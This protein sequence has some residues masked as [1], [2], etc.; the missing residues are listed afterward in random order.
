MLQA[1]RKNAY[2]WTIRVLLVVLIGVFCFWGI[3]TGFFS[4]VHPIA[5]VNGH[6][7]LGKQ[8][9]AQ[10][11]RLENTFH[12]VYGDNT[13]AVL[14][15]VNIRELALEQL[16]EQHLLESQAKRLGITVSDNE[17]AQAIKSQAAFQI[18]GQFSVR[19]YNAVLRDNQLDP[20]TFEQ[21]T[22][23]AMLVDSMRQMI[24]N[25]VQISPAQ[26]RAA[27]NRVDQHLSM[28]YVVFPYSNFV[29][30][31]HPTDKELQTFYKADKQAFREPE[32]VKI[33]YIR[34]DPLVLAS[35]FTPSEAQIQDYYQQHRDSEFTQSEEVRARHILIAV[36]PDA[37]P[38][39]H[40]A[41]KAKAEDI[42]KQLK[43]GADFA[44]LAKQYSDDPGTRDHGGELG[45]FT[46][47]EMVKPFAE[48]AFS[49]KPGQYTVAQSRFGYHIIQVQQV[50]PEQVETLAQARPK[51]I[52]ALRR[53][54]GTETARQDLDLDLASALA[55]HSLKDL[56]QKRG[57]TAVNTPFFTEAGQIRGAEDDPKL[58]QQV[59][60]LSPGDVHA[61]TNSLV[62]YLVKM[63]A[64]EPA[65]V[66]PYKD[67]EGMVRQAYINLQAESKAHQ[68]AV[69]IMK[70][71]KDTGDFNSVV[72][73]NRLDVQTTPEFSRTTREL[74]GVGPVGGIADAAAA[75]SKIPGVI[76]KVIENQGNSYIFE[77][78]TRTPP[79][80]AEWQAARKPFIQ[81]LLQARRTAA[82]IHF[83]DHL[84]RHAKIQ[85]DVNALGASSNSNPAPM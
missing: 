15:G 54:A 72:A 35:S 75:L 84:K 18:D 29:S 47:K 26:A 48:A 57:L 64:R 52:D 36:P 71:V 24:A 14:K 11:T 53:Q 23:D 81:Q 62:P 41:A 30:S 43:S 67:I 60:K 2:S 59:F 8:I 61:V 31:I 12:N 39:Q 51:I 74:P 33:D 7:I 10:V 49:L 45:F 78:L 85:I 70:Q 56:A 37:T 68:S 77:V 9:D 27:F 79:T 22:R 83:V 32:Q 19:R 13:Q 80:E 55:G 69:T 38:V 76:P 65:H 58:A 5:S 63:V 44:K 1:F 46:R 6:K 73:Q 20:A 21:D 42:L 17:L 4:H 3:G 50:K 40:A 25:A 28:A 82:F 66:P 34:Y 16:I